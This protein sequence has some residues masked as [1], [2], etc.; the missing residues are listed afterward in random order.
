EAT[1]RRAWGLGGGSIGQLHG[2][3]NLASTTLQVRSRTDIIGLFNKGVQLEFAADNGTGTSPVGRRG[4]PDRLT[5]Q[6]GNRDA[7]TAVTSAALNT[8]SS[9]TAD[10]Y[11]FRRGDY[12]AAVTGLPGWCPPTA[13]T[14]GDSFFG[15]DRTVDPVR[16]SG[17]RVTGSGGNMEEVI[18]DAG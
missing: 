4:S 2:S 10:D 13:P 14:T 7:G 11:I 9:I 1:A 18:Q 12:G 6:S 8:V 17:T 3:V 5:V 15:L 16:L